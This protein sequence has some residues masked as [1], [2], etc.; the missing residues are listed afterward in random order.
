MLESEFGI[1]VKNETAAREHFRSIAT[2]ADFVE[3]RL[4]QSVA[5]VKHPRTQS[6]AALRR[7]QHHD[8]SAIA[9]PHQ[10][11]FRARRSHRRDEKSIEGDVPLHRRT[12]RC[13][14]M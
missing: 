8:A 13:R 12:T 3:A 10:I 1:K 5:G 6:R 2:L 7:A 14:S 9:L 11:P 4:A